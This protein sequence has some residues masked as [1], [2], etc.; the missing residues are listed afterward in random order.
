M[1]RLPLIVVVLA[2]A[3]PARGD[4]V[5]EVASEPS[6]G[7]KLLGRGAVT[8]P[9]RAD[10]A[11]RNYDGNLDELRLVVQAGALEVGTLVVDRR[12][13]DDVTLDLDVTLAGETWIHPID[14]T[15]N[16]DTLEHVALDV[17]DLGAPAQ[18]W[19]FGRDRRRPE[20]APAPAPALDLVGW[21]RLGAVALDG[22]APGALAIAETQPWEQLAFVSSADIDVLAL[23]FDAWAPYLT[24][25]LRGGTR[26]HVVELPDARAVRTIDFE[27]TLVDASEGE[28]TV[29]AR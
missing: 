9:G 16:Q 6:T 12:N 21:T 11:L 20:V 15:D 18:V 1:K 13:L 28:I 4:R 26:S 27:Y 19:I 22:S 23:A 5:V 8:Q 10:I 17:L 14:L 3:V 2:V 25:K 29:Y 7:W 24:M